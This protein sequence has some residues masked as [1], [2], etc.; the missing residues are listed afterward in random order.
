[1]YLKKVGGGRVDI[2]SKHI[3]MIITNHWMSIGYVYATIDFGMTIYLLIINFNYLFNSNTEIFKMTFQFLI[4]YLKD[5]VL[6]TGATK[7][8]IVDR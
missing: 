6:V 4:H 8:V 7:D 5:F 1:M 2:P 3:I